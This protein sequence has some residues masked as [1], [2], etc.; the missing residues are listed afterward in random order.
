MGYDDI[1]KESENDRN[2]CAIWDGLYWRWIDNHAEELSK[3]PRW[4][5]M[6]SMVRKMNPEK[7]QSHRSIADDFLSTLSNN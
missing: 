3:N 6:C 4:A 7:L 5:M 1:H 2:W